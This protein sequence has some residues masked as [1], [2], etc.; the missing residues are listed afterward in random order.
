MEQVNIENLDKIELLNLLYIE[1]HRL[2]TLCKKNQKLA[3]VSKYENLETPDCIK[4]V[5]NSEASLRK[6]KINDRVS[7][8]NSRKQDIKI[9]QIKLA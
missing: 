2:Q 5:I 6:L 4:K 7:I 1:L 3:E 8:I 9:Q